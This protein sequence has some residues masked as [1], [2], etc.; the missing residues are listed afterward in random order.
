MTIRRLINRAFK[1]REQLQPALDAELQ[2]IAEALSTGRHRSP[3]HPDHMLQVR[4]TRPRTRYHYE[5]ILAELA[6]RY[7]IPEKTLDR[8]KEKHSSISIP[9]KDWSISVRGEISATRRNAA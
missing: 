2:E 9:N 7:R 5:D 8:V 6:K 1:I 4:L 3:E